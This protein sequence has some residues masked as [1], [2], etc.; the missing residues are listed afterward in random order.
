[1]NFYIQYFNYIQNM[2]S[3][4]HYYFILSMQSTNNRRH[5]TKEEDMEI[6]TLVTRNGF[7]WDLISTLLPGHTPRQIRD[8]YVN[9]LIP[10]QSL[11]HQWT[12]EEDM[13][14]TQM[15]N[16]Y[17]PKWTMFSNF[18]VG[19]T[20]NSIKNRWNTYVSKQFKS[21]TLKVGNSQFQKNDFEPIH[22]QEQCTLINKGNDILSLDFEN[23]FSDVIDPFQSWSFEIP[24]M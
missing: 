18:F 24:I 7:K 16:Q 17:G 5:F 3:L 14:L 6:R 4:S 11:R 1:M 19:R 8:R 22:Q 12:L 13:K 23:I 15:Y 9:Y 2:T 20:P 10:C 21:Y